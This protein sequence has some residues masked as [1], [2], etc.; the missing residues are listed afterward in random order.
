MQLNLT[1]DYAIRCILYLDG[2]K[3]PVPAKE[4]CEFA[5]VGKP[6]GYRVLHLL[7][8]TG[9]VG[10]KMGANGGFTLLVP[11]NQVSLLQIMK[12]TEDTVK[13]NKCLED[14]IAA[15]KDEERRT[16]IPEFFIG[17]QEYIEDILGNIF[18]SDMAEG[19]DMKTILK[20]IKK[21]KS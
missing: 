7:K 6:Y 20:R 13:I 9:I 1:T 2:K 8:E 21:T 10:M 17:L 15:V 3:G 16:K 19:R 4:I 11:I 18:V 14:D 5:G 12:A